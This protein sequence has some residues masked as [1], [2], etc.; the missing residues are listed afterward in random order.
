MMMM[1][2]QR[3]ATATKRHGVRRAQGFEINEHRSWS[4][5]LIR[6]AKEANERTCACTPNNSGIPFDNSR[7]PPP[8]A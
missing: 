7:N 1:G 5:I 8:E 6:T 4:T 2:C 3:G